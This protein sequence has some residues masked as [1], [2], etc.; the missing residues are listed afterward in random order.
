MLKRRRNQAPP[1]DDGTHCPVDECMKLL[2]GSWTPYIIWHLSVG[3]RR[4]SELE[5][6]IPPISAKVLST[7]LKE[8]C[9]KG[10]VIRTVQPT[11]P[12]SVDYTLSELGR[13]L[14]PV[15]KAIVDVGTRLKRTAGACPD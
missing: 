15:I 5:S 7:R 9:T 6:D 3:P 2:G 10:V 1:L 14:L 13:E 11:S 4:F 12:P 8:L